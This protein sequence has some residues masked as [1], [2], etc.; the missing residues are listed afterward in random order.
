[1]PQ[2]SAP[3]FPSSTIGDAAPAD[4]L[5]RHFADVARREGIPCIAWAVLV[6]GIVVASED[7]DVQSRICSMTKSFTAVALLQLRDAGVVSLDAPAATYVPELRAWPQQVTV[8]QLLT[9]TA[10]LPND[11]PWADRCL[12]WS[13]E[14]FDALLHGGATL[15]REPGRRFEYANLGWAVLGRIVAN[16]AG[17]RAQDYVTENIL[18]PLGL[19]RTT[20][21]VEEP[22]L[23]GHRT[24]RGSVVAELAPLGDGEFSPMGGLWSTP[25]DIC[26]WM[27]FLLDGDDDVLSDA[28]RVEMQTA[29][30]TVSVDDRLVAGYGYGVFVE[31][32]E[33][34][35]H[36]A[37]H[38]GGL[39]GYGSSMRWL[40]GRGVG[41]VALANLTYAPMTAA[42]RAALDLIAPPDGRT[43]VS[44]L[45]WRLVAQLRDWNPDVEGELFSENVLLDVARDERIDTAASLG[46]FT[47]GDVDAHTET[48]AVVSLR[49][50]AGNATL[51]VWLTPE[52]RPRIQRYE[53]ER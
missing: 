7:V 35:Q 47:V 33:K 29:H 42:T 46:D 22:A 34:L 41:V 8:R 51:R 49:S 40:P 30:T 36:V 3:S 45:T 27:A 12:N 23:P 28:S 1:M 20:W 18:E 4:V 44:E 37:Q 11:D 9:M 5:R 25:G 39:P 50:D 48:Y 10:G 16:V 31:E 38:P 17:R 6:D 32:D 24:V 26:R 52:P 53:V 13:A 19:T 2:D 15:A 14:A 21:T 43:A